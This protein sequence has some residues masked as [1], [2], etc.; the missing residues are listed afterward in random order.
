MLFTS[1][2]KLEAVKAVFNS[3]NLKE[4]EKNSSISRLQTEPLPLKNRV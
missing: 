2:S 1:P 3:I 4:N